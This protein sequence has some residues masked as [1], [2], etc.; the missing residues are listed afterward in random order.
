MLD[1]RRVEAAD[2]YKKD[3]LAGVLGRRLDSVEFS[4]RA[5]YLASDPVPV[6]R[7][8]PVTDRPVVAAGGSV[9]PFFAGLLPEGVRLT[10]LTRR[11]KTSADDMLTLLVAVGAETIGDVRVY[12]AGAAPVEPVPAGGITDWRDA[13]F[14]E[15]FQRSV[16]TAGDWRESAALPGVQVKVS[17]E[18]ISFPVAG[19]A[20]D[21]WILKLNPPE[22]PRLVENEAFFL[23][24]ARACGLEVPAFHL[25]ADRLGRSG[26]LVKRFERAHRDDL[27]VR[28]AQEDACQLLN[29][30]PADKYRLTYLE[31]C[32]AI[33]EVSTV[34]AVD[35]LRLVTLVAFSYL[36]GNGD[37][38]AKN[39]SAGETLDGDVRLTPAYDLLSTIAYV[40]NDRLA[41]PVD[42]RDDNLRRRHLVEFGARIGVRERPILHALDRMCDV[43]PKWSE[44]LGE[45]GLGERRTR[46][47]MT[48]VERRRQAL[49]G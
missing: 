23:G 17:T 44:R 21:R 37:L 4:Y 46:F 30:Y 42:G 1:P 26:L 43:A 16:G 34:P 24:M 25:A 38:H 14:D 36:V 49:A 48:E 28:L 10:A 29:R 19:P 8:L 32:R 47:L 2:V 5:D 15:L 41:L 9:P 12:P 27:V 3:R 31:V 33:L 18:M 35:A 11:L 40:G 20:G 45:I 6:A 13:D 39:V 22:Y 7:T